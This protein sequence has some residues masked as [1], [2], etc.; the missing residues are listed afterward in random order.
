MGKLWCEPSDAAIQDFMN[1]L[2]LNKD[3]KIDM[4]EWK[5]VQSYAMLTG[6]KPILPLP[7]SSHRGSCVSVPTT[8]HWS[9]TRS[10]L[11]ST[12]SVVVP[13]TIAEDGIEQTQAAGPSKYLARAMAMGK[14]PG[15]D[16][17]RPDSHCPY[18]EPDMAAPCGYGN[19]LMNLDDIFKKVNALT[20][21]EA[22][23]GKKIRRKKKKGKKKKGKKIRK[24]L[25]TSRSGGVS[26]RST[27]SRASL[28]PAGKKGKKRKS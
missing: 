1:R 26:R 23:K 5:A 2:D 19:D 13:S 3:D 17:E 6:K 28:R 18:D 7:E 8:S 15:L 22:K 25:L 12:G 9:A 14:V 20:A 21:K 27:R 10:R 24:S 11:S 4:N 16:S